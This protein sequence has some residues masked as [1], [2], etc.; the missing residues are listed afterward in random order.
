VNHLRAVI[1]ASLC[2]ALV[3]CGSDATGVPNDSTFVETHRAI[4]SGSVE[5]QVHQPLEGVD[6]VVQFDGGSRIDAPTTRTDGAGEFLLVLALYNDRSVASDSVAAT[7]YA[8][9]RYDDGT[10]QAASHKRVMIHFNPV[11]ADP[12]TTTVLFSLPVL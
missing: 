4:V 7:V 8:I 9:A 10:V 3:S 2:A 5:G 6:V 12:P 11:A 1:V